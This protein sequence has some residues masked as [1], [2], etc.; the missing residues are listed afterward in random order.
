MFDIF[1]AENA[2]L[3]SLLCDKK[4]KVSHTTDIWTSIMTT[5]H[6]M[7]TTHFINKDW[8]L[9]KRVISFNIVSDHKGE[10]IGKQLEKCLLDLGIK[11]VFTITVDNASA[12]KVAIVAISYMKNKLKTWR[13]DALVLNG[14]YMHVRC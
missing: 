14:Y 7:I 11:R 2:L 12:N 8:Q 9:H 5:S 6:M 13:D 1:L 4:Q 3:K 10:T